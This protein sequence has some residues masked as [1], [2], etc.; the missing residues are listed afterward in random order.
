MNR[1]SCCRWERMDETTWERTQLGTPSPWIGLLWTG[2][3]SYKR[4]FLSLACWKRISCSPAHALPILSSS[5]VLDGWGRNGTGPGLLNFACRPSL[6]ANAFFHCSF[7][8]MNVLDYGTHSHTHAHT[9]EGRD[10]EKVSWVSW[11]SGACCNSQGYRDVDWINTFS[12]PSS[13]ICLHHSHRL[14]CHHRRK[15][16][17]GNKPDHAPRVL[18]P[19]PDDPMWK[20]ACMENMQ[21]QR[22]VIYSSRNT[23]VHECIS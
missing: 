18:F 1:L 23:Y 3:W 22:R 12:F 8:F 7:G 13:F 10:V 5:S 2:V 19:V 21:T 17:I 11:V 16:Q 6:G 15:V 9:H 20:D 14:T 4:I